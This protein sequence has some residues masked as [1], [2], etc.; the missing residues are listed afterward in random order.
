[1]GFKYRINARALDRIEAKAAAR[2][3][4]KTVRM[5]VAECKVKAKGD[6]PTA[7]RKFVIRALKKKLRKRRG[8]A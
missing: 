1:M 6:T 8:D 5:L 7:R 2:A 3:I 4:N